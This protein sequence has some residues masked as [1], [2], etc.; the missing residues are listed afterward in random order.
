MS[1]TIVSPLEGEYALGYDEQ[2]QLV[3]FKPLYGNSKINYANTK[4]LSSSSVTYKQGSIVRG[5]FKKFSND[6]G[7][8]IVLDNDKNFYIGNTKDKNILVVNDKDSLGFGISVKQPSNNKDNINK[9]VQLAKSK[10]VQSIQ[11]YVSSIGMDNSTI[12][13]INKIE[14]ISINTK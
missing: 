2:K 11:C 14:L 9:L 4:G 13:L 3:I 5:A 12:N 6:E 7:T 1:Y 8:D 10:E